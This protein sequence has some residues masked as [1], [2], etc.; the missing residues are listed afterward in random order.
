MSTEEPLFRIVRGQAD[1]EEIAALTAVLTVLAQRTGAAAGPAAPRP[2]AARWFRLE[3]NAGF[4][5]S[6]SWQTAS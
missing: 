5:A 1:A 4:L 3:R 6:H 2:A